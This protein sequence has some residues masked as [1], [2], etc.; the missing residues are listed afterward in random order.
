M[1]GEESE[2][3]HI[4]VLIT[5]SRSARACA[6]RLYD[7]FNLVVRWKYLSTKCGDL[8]PELRTGNPLFSHPDGQEAPRTQYVH[9]GI[10]PLPGKRFPPLPLSL[11][12]GA[13]HSPRP[14]AQELQENSPTPHWVP[15]LSLGGTSCL[16]SFP[17]TQG[18]WA[19]GHLGLKPGKS[20]ASRDDRL[21]PPSDHFCLL[22]SLSKLPL[23]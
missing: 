19:V 22:N 20:Q 17:K 14:R 2:Q 3:K 7:P 18:S 5:V 9:T 10:C 23:P 4:P 8:R 15:R 6:V 12:W 21:V 1:D 16:P 11:P 13:S